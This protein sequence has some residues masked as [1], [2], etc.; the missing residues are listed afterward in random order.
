[1][2][3]GLTL[4]H[5]VLAEMIGSTRET[6]TL[7]LGSL[8]R[9]GVIDIDRRR[10]VVPDRDALRGRVCPHPAAQAGSPSE[11][12]GPAGVPSSRCWRCPGD[13]APMDA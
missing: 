3:L 8:R 5:E 1:L 6:V 7:T 13:A 9:E 10:I 12:S 2:V 4:T 11:V